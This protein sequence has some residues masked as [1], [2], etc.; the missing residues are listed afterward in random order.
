MEDDEVIDV[1]ASFFEVGG[2]S[3]MAG[4]LA[5]AMR[6]AFAINMGVGDV[7]TNPSIEAMA[8]LVSQRTKEGASTAQGGRKG[9]MRRRKNRN[10]TGTNQ[11]GMG[12]GTSGYSTG[13][14]GAGTGTFGFSGSKQDSLKRDAAAMG[15]ALFEPREPTR[16]WAGLVQLMPIL[17]WAP[18]RRGLVWIC[19]VLIWAAFLAE[20]WNRFGSLILALVCIRVGARLVLPFVG[21]AFKWL[22]VGKHTAGRYALWGGDYLRWWTG[23]Q[24]LFICGPRREPFTFTP[25]GG[26]FD[27]ARLPARTHNVGPQYA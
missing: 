25:N 11:S 3:L 15:A 21:I 12:T 14:W 26:L 19:F 24:L 17:L 5:A 23:E 4:Q 20:G 27:F 1:A 6:K 16:L 7:F 13:T 22:I 8:S 2:T 10:K 18:L 9:K